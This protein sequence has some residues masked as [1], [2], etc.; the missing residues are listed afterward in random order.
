MRHFILILLCSTLV[1]S[2]KK[3]KSLKPP[4]ASLLVFPQKNSECTTGVS[5][6]ESSSQVEFRWQKSNHTESY[7]LQVTNITTGIT[8]TVSTKSISAK[9]PIEKGEPYSW[10]VVS[11]N[12]QTNEKASSETWLFYNSGSESAFAPFP[13]QIV[14]PSSG[15]TVIKDVNNEIE[16]TWSGADIDDDIENYEVYFSTEPLPTT[17]VA[18]PSSDI[19][20]FK[21][22]VLSD[23]TYYWRVVTIDAEGNSSDSGIFQFKVF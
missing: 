2:C 21:V 1:F 7:E 11:K 23:T 14:F 10:V 4:E 13:A 18:S 12:T 20:V 8:Q 22:S 16:L 17:L 15:T 5:L 6:N 3:K 9:L 19:P